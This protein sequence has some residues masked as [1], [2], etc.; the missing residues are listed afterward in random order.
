[1]VFIFAPLGVLGCAYLFVLIRDDFMPPR[2]HEKLRLLN[3]LSFIPWYWWLIATLA[4]LIVLVLEGSYRYARLSQAAASKATVDPLEQLRQERQGVLERQKLEIDIELGK[5]Q[6][7]QSRESKSKLSMSTDPPLRS[8][9][10]R[11]LTLQHAEPMVRTLYDGLQN[12]NETKPP[13]IT[14]ISIGTERETLDYRNDFVVPFEAAGFNVLTEEWAAGIPEYESFVDGVT[15]LHLSN[16][17]T[18]PVRP[19][20][21]QALRSAGIVPRETPL[22]VVKPRNRPNVAL[23]VGLVVNAP[24]AYLVIGQRRSA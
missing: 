10:P 24:A 1:M 15:V 7:R 5:E 6:L 16:D 14:I 19:I 22:P 11:R 8:Y 20:V 13:R 12:L 23:V 3:L 17:A 18:N 2:Y 9:S 21:L 4:I